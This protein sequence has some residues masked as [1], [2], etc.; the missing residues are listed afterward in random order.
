MD[1]VQGGESTFADG[2]AIAE[3]LRFCS[4]LFCFVDFGSEIGQRVI[5]SDLSSS[6]C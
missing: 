5:D 2:F 4:V 1:K 3:N 6:S